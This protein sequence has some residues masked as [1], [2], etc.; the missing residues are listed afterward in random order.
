M[1]P[2]PADCHHAVPTALCLPAPQTQRQLCF[3]LSAE[4]SVLLEAL[5]RAG[6]TRWARLTHPCV[7]S[8]APHVALLI[9]SGVRSRTEA[10]AQP[11]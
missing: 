1:A 7:A 4:L 5:T 10:R 8:P 2:S 11:A 9:P 6:D 3:V